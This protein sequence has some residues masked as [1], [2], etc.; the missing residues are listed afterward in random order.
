M[1]ESVVVLANLAAGNGRSRRFAKH[2][3]ALL[4]RDGLA[5][6]TVISRGPGHLAETAAAEAARGRLRLVALGGDG[7]LS[8]VAHGLLSVPGAATTLGIVP[9]GTGN[10]FVKSAGL[11]RDWQAAC[12]GL[13]AGCT[14]RRIDAGRVNGRWFING[15][16][17]GFDAAIAHAT[18]RHK[19]LPGPLGYAVGL[20]DALRAGVGRPVCTLRWDGGED[21]RAVTLVAA[22]NGQYA[23]GLFR[24]APDARLDDGR[25]D[26]VWADAL[27]RLQVLRHAPSVMRGTHERLPIAHRA[28]ATRFEVTSDVPLPAQADGELLGED[29]VRLSIELSPGVLRLWT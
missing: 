2:A 7:T 18:R 11:P 1:P 8:E 16:G 28:R 24:L 23:G 21:R 26:I 9:L 27:G 10:D 22:C 20:L 19:W 29:L 17:L 4:E 12:R 25:L 3:V 6:E 5:V 13:A 14:P 15:V